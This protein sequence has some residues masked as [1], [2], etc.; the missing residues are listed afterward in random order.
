LVAAKV[1]ERLAV[2]KTAVQMMDMQRFNLKKLNEGKVKNTISLQ[3]Q[4]SLQLWKT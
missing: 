2:S 4:T 1:R 3:S